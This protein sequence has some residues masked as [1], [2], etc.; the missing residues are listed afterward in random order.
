MK[1]ILIALLFVTIHLAAQKPCP[2]YG[3]KPVAKFMMLDS[4]KNRS[5]TTEI[6]SNIK[7]EDILTF[8]GDDTKRYNSSNYVELTGYII[9]V[10]WGGAETCNCHSKSKDDLDIHIELALSPDAKPTEA[11]VLEI[12]RFT[13]DIRDYKTL[14]QLVGQRV[15]V[16]G[17]MMLD[18]EHLNNAVTTNPKGKRNWRYTCWELHPLL[19]IYIPFTR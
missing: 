9:L 2:I 12:N 11:M 16:Q 10:K 18:D 17:Y 5:I 13:K 1:S 4:L 19:H 3:D 8:K 6:N 15:T 7:L 14:K